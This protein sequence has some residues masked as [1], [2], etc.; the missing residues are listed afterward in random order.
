MFTAWTRIEL[1][2]GKGRIETLD[3]G[4]VPFDAKGGPDLSKS[5]EV[6]SINGTSDAYQ[7]NSGTLVISGGHQVGQPAPYTGELC[8]RLTQQ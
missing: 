5:T 6:L 7:D 2:N 8:M 3:Q 1:D 4:T